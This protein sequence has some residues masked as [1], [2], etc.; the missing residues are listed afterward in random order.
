MFITRKENH[1]YIL[2]HR[3]LVFACILFFAW[4]EILLS[5]ATI[6]NAKKVHH[7]Y[8]QDSLHVQISRHEESSIVMYIDS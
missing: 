3:I 1:Y 4:P 6:I 8:T 2:S 7:S 5:V